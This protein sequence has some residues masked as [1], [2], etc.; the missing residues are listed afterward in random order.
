MTGKQE[1]QNFVGHHGI[2]DEVSALQ[3]VELL[4]CISVYYFNV[5]YAMIDD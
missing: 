1:I 2:G 3:F 4:L 5:D